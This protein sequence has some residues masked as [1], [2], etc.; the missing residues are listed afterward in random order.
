MSLIVTQKYVLLSMISFVVQITRITSRHLRQRDPETG[1][2]REIKQMNI[3]KVSITTTL[4]ETKQTKES[5]LFTKKIQ[6]LI[7]NLP[8]TTNFY[9]KKRKRAVSETTSTSET[10]GIKNVCI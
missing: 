9:T 5:K 6:N 3:K 2:V 4:E 1:T 7:K 8:T 10:T